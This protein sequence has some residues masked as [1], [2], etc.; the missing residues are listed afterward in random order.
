LIAPHYDK[1]SE[2]KKLIKEE[3]Q[4]ISDIEKEYSTD[5][6]CFHEWELHHE[7]KD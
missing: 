2:L 7:E 5:G 6:K 4:K 3:E 1:I